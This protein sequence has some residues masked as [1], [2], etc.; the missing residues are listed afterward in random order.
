MNCRTLLSLT[1]NS[2]AWDKANYRNKVD[3]IEIPVRQSVL[4]DTK[5]LLMTRVIAILIEL[6]I[7]VTSQV[8]LI[9]TWFIKNV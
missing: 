7:V 5:D 8:W 3:L 6:Q 1:D 9:K 4:T 2:K